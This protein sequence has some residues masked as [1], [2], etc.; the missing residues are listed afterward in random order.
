MNKP[1]KMHPTKLILYSHLP[2]ISRT[3]KEWRG[4]YAGHCW[5]SKEINQWTP[6]N[7]HNSVIHAKIYILSKRVAPSDSRWG[8][9]TRESLWWMFV[10]YVDIFH[11]LVPQFRLCVYIWKGKWSIRC[12]RRGEKSIQ[13]KT[14]Q[15]KLNLYI[16]KYMKKKILQIF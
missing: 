6:T 3:I 16:K 7:G 10:E 13:N 1:W 5:R 9:V 8:R 4:R 2:L 14:V 12:E 11:V 15:T